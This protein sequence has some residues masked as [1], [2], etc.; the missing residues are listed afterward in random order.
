M[1]DQSR[2]LPIYRGLIQTARKQTHRAS[3]L[4]GKS[5]PAS[6]VSVSGSI[7]TVKIEINSE[8]TIPHITVP[9]LGSE[10]IRLPIQAGCKGMVISSEYYIGA[11]SG[12]GPGVADMRIQGNMSNLVFVPLGNKKWAS[13]SADVLTM[14]GVSGV[15]LSDKEGSDN[16]VS[17]TSDGV[18]MK[19][20][21]A[22]V[23]CLENSVIMKTSAASVECDAAGVS[24]IGALT[25]NGQAYTAH[26]HT[27]GN[28]GQP[29]GGV[30]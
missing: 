27:N 20:S 12:L 25:I 3:E 13:V 24:I 6:V 8:F 4:T 16:S 5:M 7:A 14:Y 28:E 17:I 10:Y 30:I 15:L 19:T 1:S 11:M 29:T 26:T 23:E 9:I 21:G 2:K 22:S 18:T